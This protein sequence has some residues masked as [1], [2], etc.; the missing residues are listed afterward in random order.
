MVSSRYRSG[1]RQQLDAVVSRHLS[2]NTHATL[3]AAFA[4]LAMPEIPKEEGSRR[5]DRTSS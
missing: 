4:E 5:A 1:L 3:N 2:G